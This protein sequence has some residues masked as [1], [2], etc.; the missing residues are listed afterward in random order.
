MSR[1]Q[2]S[3]LPRGNLAPSVPIALTVLP[4][5]PHPGADWWWDEEA[6]ATE[7]RSEDERVAA[8]WPAQEIARKER[9]NA[10]CA[11]VAQGQGSASRTHTRPISGVLVCWSDSLAFWEGG[12]EK[13]FHG[14]PPTGES[15]T[16]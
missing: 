13:A 7:R 1:A 15:A 4:I 2:A 10:V 6:R 12:N 14:R 8:Y 11:S 5:L 16:P 9:E 3:P